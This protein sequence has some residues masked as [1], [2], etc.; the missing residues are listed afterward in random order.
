MSIPWVTLDSIHLHLIG[1]PELQGSQAVHLFNWAH[2]SSVTKE[3]SE[4]RFW[5]KELPLAL[6]YTQ[7]GLSLVSLCTNLLR[8]QAWEA[9]LKKA[10]IKAHPWKASGN[11]DFLRVFTILRPIWVVHCGCLHNVVPAEY[12]LSIWESGNL[13]HAAQKGTCLNN[14]Q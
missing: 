10:Y 6:Q 13:V 3:E 8:E 2:C 12:L 4:N 1:H 11:L 7:G 5:G 9:V 14:P